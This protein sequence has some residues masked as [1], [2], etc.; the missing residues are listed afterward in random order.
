VPVPRHAVYER[1]RALYAP[2]S[3][4]EATA[5][6]RERIDPRCAAVARGADA[7]IVLRREDGFEMA[8][9]FGWSWT[10][11]LA[12]ALASWDGSAVP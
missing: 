10:K 9:G 7:V 12:Q 6:A 1:N 11:A 5:I 4:E 2:L 8:I 3:Q